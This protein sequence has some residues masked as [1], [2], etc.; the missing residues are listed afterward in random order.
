MVNRDE[1]RKKLQSEIDS[2]EWAW[3]K[4]HAEQDRLIVVDLELDL[5]EV[6]VTV[7][8]G[9]LGAVQ[10]WMKLS[11]LTKPTLEQIRAFDADE[12]R[13]FKCL[14]VQPWVFIQAQSN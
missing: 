6:A 2:A 14:I 12:R 7:A 13:S 9:D 3:L 8:L 1:L 11:Q 5:L 10:E 4:P